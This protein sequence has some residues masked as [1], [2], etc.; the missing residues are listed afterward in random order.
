[1]EFH[2]IIANVD[3]IHGV[4]FEAV[5][6]KLALIG[7]VRVFIMSDGADGVRRWGMSHGGAVQRMRVAEMVGVEDNQPGDGVAGRRPLGDSWECEALMLCF[8]F[9][10]VAFVCVAN[11]CPWERSGW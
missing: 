1:M 6:V 8:V 4:T 5:L 3:V 11:V 9:G 2:L 10:I 7:F